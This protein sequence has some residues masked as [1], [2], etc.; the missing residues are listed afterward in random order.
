MRRYIQ[1]DILRARADQSLSLEE[2]RQRLPAIFA[3]QAHESRS[4]RYVYI[5]TYDVLSKLIKEGFEPV[6]ARV[7][8]TR[9]ETKK[10][11]TKHMVRLRQRSG[12]IKTRAVGD[13]HFEVVMRNA[14]DGSAAYDFMAGLFRLVCLNGMV[15]SDGNLGA[16]HVRHSG[17]QS[18][19]LGQV[20]DAVYSVVE[21]APA[22]LE[23]PRVWS[24]IELK[25]DEQM[26]MAEAARTIRFSDAEGNVD[27]PIEA[28]QL[29]LPRRSADSGNDL[30]T[31]F[32]RLQE[33]AIRGGLTGYRRNQNNQLRRSTTR[34]VRGIDSDIKLNKALWQLGVKMA[35][36]KQAA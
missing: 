31:T 34:E 30:W 27:S 26:A 25:R 6:E 11:F 13:T 10:G 9:D 23:A 15:V 35:E 24:T 8:R 21:H 22:V 2:M 14:H 32:N 19:Q 20:I 36:L 12:E 3:E 29:L 5:P 28:G 16:A 18:K 7:S 1:D 33:N 4:D 17:N